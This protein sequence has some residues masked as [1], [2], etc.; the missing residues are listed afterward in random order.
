VTNP[1]AW[2]HLQVEDADGNAQSWSIELIGINTLLKQGW[3]PDVLQPGDVINV[4][5]FGARDGSTSANASE[6]TMVDTDEQLW[7]SAPREDY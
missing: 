2:I 6:I 7:V 1:H 5:G 3:T 4:K